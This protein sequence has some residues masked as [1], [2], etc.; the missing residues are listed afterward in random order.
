MDV[1]EVFRRQITGSADILSHQLQDVLEVF[2]AAAERDLREKKLLR[3]S[4]NRCPENADGAD[5]SFETSGLV[6]RFARQRHFGQLGRLKAHRRQDVVGRCQIDLT[7][8]TKSYLQL[9]T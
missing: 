2:D 9:L 4:R 6:R 8:K 5:H 7:S 3:R 1:W